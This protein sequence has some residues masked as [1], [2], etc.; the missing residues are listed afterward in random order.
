M[1]D[2]LESETPVGQPRL[3]RL[4][5]DCGA[6]MEIGKDGRLV[7]GDTAAKFEL[8]HGY[9]IAQKTQKPVAVCACRPI[10]TCEPDYVT[11]KAC[12]ECGKPWQ[13]IILPNAC[14]HPT[15]EAP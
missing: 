10:A 9:S 13:F 6:P 8:H 4:V 11:H 5:C 12:C 14:Q 7:C 1:S 3:V 2:K 15:A